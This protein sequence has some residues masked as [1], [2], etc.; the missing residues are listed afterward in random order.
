MNGTDARLRR[1][2]HGITLVELMVAMLIGLI[3]IGGAITTLLANRQTYR[4]NDNLARVQETARIAFE[5]MARDLRAAGG[6][7]CARGIPTMSVLLPAQAAS[8]AWWSLPGDGIRGFDGDTGF[9]AVAFGSANGARIAGTAAIMTH[10]AYGTGLSVEAHNAASA[11]FKV[12]RANHDIRP[13]DV[14]MV[15]DYQQASIFQVTN[16]NAANRTIVHNTGTGSIGNCSKGLGFADPVVCTATGTPKVYGPN[17]AIYRYS[18]KAW[19]IGASNAGRSLFSIELD[20]D[21]V[22]IV[23]GVHDMQIAY[24]DG[25]GAYRNAAAISDW[26]AVRAVRVALTLRANQHGDVTQAGPERI[27]RVLTHTVSLRNRLP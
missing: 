23:P 13:N 18:A 12:N 22:E 21:P 8:P 24:L 7:G 4:I 15:C 14:L 5:L 25:N 20:G 9:A 16:A 17:S 10:G 3:V 19:Y 1:G 26:G 27:D 6:N 2:Q 11:Q